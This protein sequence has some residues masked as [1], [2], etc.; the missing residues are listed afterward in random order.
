M[1]RAAFAM[2]AFVTFT[3][4]V[5]AVSATEEVAYQGKTYGPG[6]EPT[7]PVIDAPAVAAPPPHAGS[8]SYWSKAHPSTLPDLLSFITPILDIFSSGAGSSSIQTITSIFGSQMTLHQGLTNTRTDSYG[9]LLRQGSAAVLNSYTYSS[10]PYNPT[11]VKSAFRGAL[12]SQQA[13]AVQ[14]TKFENA[15]IAYGARN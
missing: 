12:V 1:A 14:A 2:L 6:Y 5:L 11:Q 7:P 3:C 4:Y 9:A 10:Y 8:C 15:N 13:A